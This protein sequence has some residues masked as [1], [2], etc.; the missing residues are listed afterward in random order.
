MPIPFNKTS[1]VEWEENPIKSDVLES[2]NAL[3][4][5]AKLLFSLDDSKLEELVRRMIWI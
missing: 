5:A 3:R 2:V 4:L 1:K